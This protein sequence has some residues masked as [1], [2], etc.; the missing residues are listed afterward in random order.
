M[1]TYR[2]NQTNA[3]FN[4]TTTSDEANECHHEADDHEYEK[5]CSI[6]FCR[7]IKINILFRINVDE[8]R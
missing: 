6:V 3:I 7:Y 8:H 1:I 5:W 4:C 2:T